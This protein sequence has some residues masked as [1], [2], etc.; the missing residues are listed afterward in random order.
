MRTPELSVCFELM[1]LYD[2]EA[3]EKVISGYWKSSQ[4]WKVDFLSPQSKVIHTLTC[5]MPCN[6]KW[7]FRACKC[8]GYSGM[9]MSMRVTGKVHMCPAE[10]ALMVSY[11]ERNSNVQYSLVTNLPCSK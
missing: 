11:D 3:W 6:P 9:T 10:K 7:W 8:K 2:K 4:G 1:R 5:E